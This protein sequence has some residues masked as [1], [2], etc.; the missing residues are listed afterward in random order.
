[1]LG[2]IVDLAVPLAVTDAEADL[3]R[4]YL[5]ALLDGVLADEEPQSR[6]NRRPSCPVRPSL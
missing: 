4:Q 1:M 5:G 3:I 2:V 6:A